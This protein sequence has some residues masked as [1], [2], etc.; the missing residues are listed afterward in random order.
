M[1]DVDFLQDLLDVIEELDRK[2]G[3]NKSS[4]SGGNNYGIQGTAIGFDKDTQYNTFVDSGSGLVKFYREVEGQI[5]ITL[6]IDSMARI[7][8]ITNEKESVIEMGGDAAVNIEIRQ[9]N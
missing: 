3:I 8:T 9:T 7:Y 6:P 2:V 4:S 1:L 5:S